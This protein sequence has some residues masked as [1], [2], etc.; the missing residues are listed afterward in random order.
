MRYDVI[1]VLGN[2]FFFFFFNRQKACIQNQ[3]NSSLEDVLLNFGSVKMIIFYEGSEA[4]LQSKV[5]RQ[6]EVQN[7]DVNQVGFAAAMYNMYQD[8]P[9]RAVNHRFIAFIIQLSSPPHM[10]SFSCIS[11]VYS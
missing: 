5:R 8:V 2:R 11:E 7:K 6:A 10:H 1:S 3:P 4:Y 9:C